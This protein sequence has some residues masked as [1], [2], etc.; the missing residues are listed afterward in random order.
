MLLSRFCVVNNHA[1]RDRRSIPRIREKRRVFIPAVGSIDRGELAKAF[2]SKE[3]V[4]RRRNTHR[5]EKLL[6]RTSE[7]FVIKNACQ[8]LY[9]TPPA[10]PLLSDAPEVKDDHIGFTSLLPADPFP[11]SRE[12]LLFRW[13]DLQDREARSYSVTSHKKAP[14][15]TQ[16]PAQ[17]TAV[18]RLLDKMP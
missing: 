5:R 14:E 16:G 10:A 12:S 17:P 7:P 6:E 3:A 1:G 9:S 2:V 18:E 13:V 4:N 8:R 15:C 11:E